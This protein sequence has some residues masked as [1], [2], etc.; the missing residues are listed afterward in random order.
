M[1]LRQPIQRIAQLRRAQRDIFVAAAGP[2]LYTFDAQDGA[3]LDVW[4]APAA[5]QHSLAGENQPLTKDES[6]PDR[7]GT[8]PPEKKRKLSP[9]SNAVKDESNTQKASTTWTTIPLLLCTPSGEHVIAVTAED[10]CLRVFAI[11]IDGTLKQQSERGMPKRPCALALAQ[12]D[13]VIL[14]GDKFGDVYSLPLVPDENAKPPTTVTAPTPAEEPKAFKPS[15]NPLTVHTKKNLY[16]LQQQL[17]SPVVKR[18]KVGPSFELK[19]L[20]G[21]VSML[22]DLAFVSV[23]AESRSYILSADRDE[24]IRVSRG[25]PQAHIIHGYCQGHT[26]FISK[27]CIPSWSPELLVSGGGDSYI[28]VWNWREGSILQRIPLQLTSQ[29]NPAAIAVT[30]I[31]AVSFEG[32]TNL[33]QFA[34]G[35]ILVSIEGSQEI[36]SFGVKSDNTLEPLPAINASGNVLDITNLDDKGTIIVSSDHVH[37]PGST[38]QQK[39]SSESPGTPL[40]Q[41]TA[42]V[43]SGSLRW[44]ESHSPAL[45]RI[46][47]C[48][49]FSFD[50]PGDEKERQKQLKQLGESLY[51]TGNLR[52]SVR[53]EEEEK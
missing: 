23:P 44:E 22:T 11:G 27:M 43:N 33:Y 16:S 45:S 13:S 20:L 52:K 42:T 31:R 3:Q 49:S 39:P 29:S 48:S 34:K 35:V 19:L 17:R 26:S 6:T 5:D 36:L 37:E 32:D 15:A 40:Q 12:N 9:T 24:H 21:H 51:Y 1:A 2:N 4:P 50:L 28:V 53:G 41:F 14:C 30:G 25:L 38:T 18:E 47:A 46:N 7:A 10:K 8:P